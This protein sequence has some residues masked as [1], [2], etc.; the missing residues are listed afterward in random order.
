M[1]VVSS[2]ITMKSVDHSIHT[3]TC[4]C[5]LLWGSFRTLIDS[6]RNP[7]FL[8]R[9]SQKKPNI[10]VIF[11]KAIESFSFALMKLTHNLE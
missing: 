11:I 4:Y 3:W 2:T 1:M 9:F 6:M 5:F 8:G 7:T 10:S